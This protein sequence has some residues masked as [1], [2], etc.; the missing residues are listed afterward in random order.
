M[1]QKN[2]DDVALLRGIYN[3][4][5]LIIR[6]FYRLV[7]NK[8]YWFAFKFLKD[9]Q[10]V[11]DAVNDAFLALLNEQSA[12]VS[13]DNIYA[14]LYNRVRWNCW[15][16]LRPKADHDKL[17]S[18]DE[19]MALPDEDETIEDRVVKAEV[20]NMILQEIER[21]PDRDKKILKLYFFEEKETQ[22]IA[23]LLGM[24]V[25]TVH[26]T[27]RLLLKYIRNEL[28]RKAL[29]F[30]EWSVFSSFSLMTLIRNTSIIKPGYM[31]TTNYRMAELVYKHMTGGLS[32]A[33][34]IELNQILTDPTKRKL[35][36]DLIDLHNTRAEVK[37]MS[38]GDEKAS[39][40]QIEAAYPFHN[41]THAWKK[42]LAAAAVFL[43][44]AVG[45]TWYYWQRPARQMVPAVEPGPV[46]A[47][48]A[49]YNPSSRKAIWKRAANLAVY[50]DDLRNGV[51]GYADGMPV[52]KNDSE[53][54]YPAARRSDIPLPDTV[55]TLRGGYY[56]LQLPDGS[57]VVLNSASSVFFASAFGT[58]ERQ[59]S[60]NGEAYFDVVKEPGRPFIVQV[61]GLEIEVL[62]TK[63]NVQA[64]KEENIIRTSLVEGKVKVRAGKQVAYLKPGEQAVL[65]QKKKLEKISDSSVVK[66]AT[67]WK[68]GAFIFENDNLKTIM[69]ELGRWY[70]LDIT[71]NG[72]LSNKPYYGVFSRRD[73][74]TKVLDFLHLQTGIRYTLEGKKLNIQP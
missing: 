47:Q 4:D 16:A 36:E 55:Q 70:D 21:L 30:R 45:V 29:F 46:I 22:E 27:R 68:D 57:K 25:K 5:K 6:E 74:I 61:P 32:E 64:Y 34:S 71:Y 56:R 10:L 13:I 52:I 48:F 65:T 31:A 44:L 18:T 38:E 17:R 62:G 11:N 39:W 41:K 33:D 7:Y 40:Q 51:V 19:L 35:F 50:L 60:V 42:Y 72:E 20:Y 67:A 28:I 37:I 26:N 12:F 14:W 53:L 58:K 8:F 15:A 2:I 63:F 23:E 54:V 73:P 9:K 43:P 1:K 66:K 3:R 49:S 24:N 59:V 69:D